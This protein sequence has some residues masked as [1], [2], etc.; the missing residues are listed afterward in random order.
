ML[1]DS[2]LVLE[3]GGTRALFSAGILDR[4]IENRIYEY[5]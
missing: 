1:V 5:D 2:G 3:G 4:L